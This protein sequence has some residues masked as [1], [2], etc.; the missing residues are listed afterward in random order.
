MYTVVWIMLVT[1]SLL[2]PK[3]YVCTLFSYLSWAFDLV[4]HTNF[5]T[6]FS[7][8]SRAFDLVDHTNVC[9]IYQKPLTW[10]TVRTLVPYSLIYPKSETW[11]TIL[12]CENYSLGA[13]SVFRNQKQLDTS[14]C[15]MTYA[16]GATLNRQKTI[17]VDLTQAFDLIDRTTIL[18][19]LP[20]Y[21]LCEMTLLQHFYL[22]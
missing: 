18:W 12:T 14:S 17:F 8:L 20:P 10:L 1:Y 5:G 19:T 4:D 22:P 2:Y 11:L 15:S 13:H 21:D 6:L 3:V 9:L 16:V 7:Y